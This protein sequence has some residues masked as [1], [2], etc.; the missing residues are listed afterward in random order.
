VQDV[1]EDWRTASK[2][3]FIQMDNVSNNTTLIEELEA[4]KSPVN[5]TNHLTNLQIGLLMT[6]ALNIVPLRTVFDV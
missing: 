1:I 2:L 3:S 6:L 4:C 5:N